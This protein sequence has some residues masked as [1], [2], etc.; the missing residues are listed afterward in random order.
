MEKSL[1]FQ[2]VNKYFPQLVASVVEKLNGKNQTAL[3][4]MYRDHLTNTY[5]QDGRWASITAEYTRVAADVVSMDAELPLKS[6]D[7]V[8]T[9]EVKSQRLV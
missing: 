7:K 6:R 9:A 1:Y 4:Y 3:T 8:S 5:S 2:L